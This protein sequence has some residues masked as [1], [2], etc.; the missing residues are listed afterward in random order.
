MEPGRDEGPT[1][2][3]SRTTNASRPTGANTDSDFTAVPT[4]GLCLSRS[5]GLRDVR[6]QRGVLADR[7]LKRVRATYPHPPGPSRR[8]I[9]LEVLA[10]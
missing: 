8:P 5:V 6:V 9:G 2:T 4:S 10:S 7:P 3:S 1:I